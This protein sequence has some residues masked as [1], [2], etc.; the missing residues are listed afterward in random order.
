MT[1]V[2]PSLAPIGGD[3]PPGELPGFAAVSAGPLG[4]A[5]ILAAGF[6]SRLKPLTDL[7]PKPLFPVLNQPMLRRWLGRLRAL[8]VRRAV[9]NAHHLAQD[10]KKAVDSWRDEL[11]GLE[12]VVLFEPVILGSGGG[13]KNAAPFLTETF[14]L[15]NVDIFSDLDL[16]LLA[17]RHLARPGRPATLAAVER[18]DRATVSL[19]ADGRV[20]GF[21]SPRPLPDEAAK[22]CGAGLMVVEPWF[23]RELPDGPSDVI[24]ELGRWMLRG[25]A[26]GAEVFAPELWR[27]MGTL[28]EYWALNRDLAQG[29]I[30]AENPRG[31]L[32]RLEGFV[33][34][35]AGA[36]VAPGGRVAD[37][38]LWR[39]A[40]VEDGA[41][42]VGAVVAGRVPAGETVAGGAVRP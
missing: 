30:W 40:V 28:E 24:E 5:M 42:A 21:R 31:L 34:A 1:G 12:I 27:D 41:S 25:P 11:D 39:G 20:L 26:P 13:L 3:Q 10:L 36:V 9:V 38:V 35:Q 4:A 32:G 8:G 6:G 23:L 17:R 22:L 37:S 16:A 18:P 33:V 7:K 15:V 29:R 19:A 14:Y 2:P